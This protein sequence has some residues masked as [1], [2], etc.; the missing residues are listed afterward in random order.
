MVKLFHEI[1]PH[2]PVREVEIHI[3]FLEVDGEKVAQFFVRQDGEIMETADWSADITIGE[4]NDIA[5]S[6]IVAYFND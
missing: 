4:A 5:N 3:D 6:Y 2:E 1:F